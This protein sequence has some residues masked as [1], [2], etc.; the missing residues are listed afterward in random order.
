MEGQRAQSF[1]LWKDESLA[2][3]ELSCAGGGKLRVWNAWSSDGLAS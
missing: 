3:L 1:L 2:D